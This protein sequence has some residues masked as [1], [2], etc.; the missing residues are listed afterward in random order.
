VIAASATIPNVN[1]IAAWLGAEEMDCKVYGDE[2]RPVQINTIVK[3]FAAG[4]NDFLFERRL[5][6]RVFDVVKQYWEQKPVLTFVS[7]RKGMKSCCKLR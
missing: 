3:G 5:S 6:E 1:D 2:V 4:K 7:S